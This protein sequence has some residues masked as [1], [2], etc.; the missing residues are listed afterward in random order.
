MYCILGHLTM[1]NKNERIEVI[2]S[3]VSDHKG[4]KLDINDRN[5]FGRFLSI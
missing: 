2:Q 4:I 5:I 1:L 3:K